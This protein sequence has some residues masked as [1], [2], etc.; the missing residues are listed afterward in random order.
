MRLAQVALQS[1]GYADIFILNTH[2]FSLCK[3]MDVGRVPSHS[4]KGQAMDEYTLTLLI[5]L[6]GAVCTVIGWSMG[7][8]Q[9]SD[10]FKRRLGEQHY[11]IRD[12]LADLDKQGSESRYSAYE[13]ATGAADEVSEDWSNWK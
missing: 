13:I 12:L 7:N 10:H 9:A 2:S 1:S 3:V 8:A 6:F 5:F 4:D 11:Q